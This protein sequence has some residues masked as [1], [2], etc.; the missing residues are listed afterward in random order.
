MQPPPVSVDLD[1]LQRDLGHR[2]QNQALLRQ[3]LTHRSA[4]SQ[5]YERLEFLGDNVLNL[6]VS[7][8]LYQRMPDKQEGELSR[9]RAGLV[10]QANLAQIAERLHLEQLLVL[11]DGEARSGG[12]RRPSILA[13]AVEALIGALYLDAGYEEAR[14]F[15]VK[16][17]SPML[18]SGDPSALGKDAKTQLQEWLQGRG[19]PLPKYEVVA[20]RGA[21]H[22]Q[23]FEVVC[24]VSRPSPLQAKAEGLSRRAAE[25]LAAAEMLPLLQ[26]RRSRTHD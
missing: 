10:C 9:I 14:S 26:T 8:L 13:D 17:V 19:H 5:H 15:V 25:Q 21:A 1:C 7:H 11:G 20:T 12:A 6:S 2:F 16:S 23:V 22:E 18:E 3:A 4:S 24:S